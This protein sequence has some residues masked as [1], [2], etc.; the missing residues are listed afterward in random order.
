MPTSSEV[1]DSGRFSGQK[2]VRAPEKSNFSQ[3]CNLLS[4]YLK[5]KGTFGDLNLGISTGGLA[6]PSAA[7]MNLFPAVDKSGQ[8][9]AV[10][11]PRNLNSINF[12][13]LQAG[14]APTPAKQG[15]PNMA[16]FSFSANK[17]KPEFAAQM[18]IFYGG[19]VIVFNDFPAEKA[20]E[21]MLLAS[22]GSRQNPNTFP[23]TTLVQKP[24]EPSKLVVAPNPT[25]VPS[26]TNNI[27]QEHIQLQQRTPPP[28]VSDL[29][30]ARKASLTRFLEKRK[31]RITA[32]APY[33]AGNSA[34]AEAA[35]VPSKAAEGK[36]WLGLA[37]QSP[38]PF[39]A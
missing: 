33:Q 22:K 14:F 10:P 6:A 19:Q 3:T 7:T 9:S 8:N 36:S 12:F 21:I 39:E 35:P 23:S 24:A 5:E 17:P 38:L 16:D 28:V 25:V 32:R 34:A 18:T 31:D 2:M 29:P 26:F 27:V 11:A 15:V 1:V 30:I 13:P 20:K 37:S 4:Q